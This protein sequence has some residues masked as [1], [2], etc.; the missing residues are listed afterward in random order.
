MTEKKLTPFKLDHIQIQ[1]GFWKEYM[2]LVRNHV[3][4]YQWEALN[5]RIENA[6]PS[7][8][9]ENFRVAAKL[10]EGNFQGMVFQDSDVYK[11]LEAVAYSL[12]WH[13]DPELEKTADETIDLIAAAQQPDGYLDTYYIINGLDKRFTNLMDHHEM[14]CLGH[15]TEAAVAYYYA[16]G[17]RKFLDTAIG[18]AN[19]AYENLGTEEGK[20]PGYPGHEVAEMALIGLYGITKNEK[21]LKLAKYFIDQRGQAPLFFDEE[22]KKNG[23][24]CYWDDSYMKKQYYQAGKPVREQDKA[25]GHAV[26]AVY[27][28]SGMADVASASDDEELFHVC[29]KIWD[30]IVTKQMYV[31]GAIGSTE[32][33]EAFSFDYDLPNDTVYAETCAAIGLIFFARRMFEITKD[34]RY[35]DVMERALFN[36]VISGMSLDGKKFFYV[37]PLEVNPEACEKDYF[38]R[39]VKPVRQKWFGCACCPPNVARLLSSIGG[40]AYECSEDSVYMNLFIGGEMDAV[41]GGVSNTF[42]VETEYP[43]KQDVKIR[44]ENQQ[45]SQYVYAVRIPGWCKKYELTIN[46]EKEEYKVEKGYAIL[47]RMWK[48]GD[49]IQFSMDMPVELVEAN[50]AVREDIGKVAVMRGPVVYCLEETDN[51]DQLQEVYLEEVPGFEAAFEPD[52]LKGVVTIKAKGKRVSRD[53]WSENTL[54]RTYRGKVFKSQELKFI[55]YYAWT[56]REPGEMTVWVRI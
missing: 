6:E 44:V 33:G 9:I 28:Y 12:M 17:K 3:I 27:L 2:E 38:K 18:Y 48:N 49:E 23:N 14:Y 21:H 52:L 20:I 5:D 13:P 4:P 29:E 1:D 35:T 31:T 11:W 50:P 36:G 54:Y 16:T 40:Y 30:N 25:E 53:D 42:T 19:C 22:C 47:D 10:Q 15:M 43:W 7:H 46:G 34:S 32:H 24:V 55:P 56:N 8:C 41:V 39:H 26:R 45:D 51:G 37:N